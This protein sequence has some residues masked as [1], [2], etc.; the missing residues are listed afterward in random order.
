MGPLLDA[1]RALGATVDDD[2]R[3]TLPFTVV[4]SLLGAVD[5][6]TSTR[7]RPRSS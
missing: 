1:L 3:G 4:A 6:S 7:R 5:R 2:G